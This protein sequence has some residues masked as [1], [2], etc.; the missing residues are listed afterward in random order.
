M[1]VLSVNNN[2]IDGDFI[3]IFI[4][5]SQYFVGGVL[6]SIGISQDELCSA[7]KVFLLE[8]AHPGVGVLDSARVLI[9]FLD[10]FYNLTSVII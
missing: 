8:P 9:F 1:L 6:I 10:L 4:Y 3:Y 2:P 7:G 5:L